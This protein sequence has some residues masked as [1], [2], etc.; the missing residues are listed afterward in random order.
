MGLFH[1]LALSL[2]AL[3]LAGCQNAL[4][5]MVAHVTIDAK[6]VHAIATANAAVNVCLADKSIDRWRAFEFSTTAAQFL[7]LVVFDEGYYKQ[8][9]EA[10][11]TAIA[12]ASR[13]ECQSLDGELPKFTAFLQE[14]HAKISAQL[15]RMRSEENEQI[16]RLLSSYRAGGA[17]AV[18][19]QVTFPPLQYRQEQPATQSYLVNTRQGLVQCRITNN[20]YV[21]CL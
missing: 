18:N 5:T 2:A 11:L 13:N 14:N 4:K 20:S 7:D 19:P 3:L 17:G 1:A 21:F 10:Q 12:S 9:Y 6:A 16:M 15:G 8:V